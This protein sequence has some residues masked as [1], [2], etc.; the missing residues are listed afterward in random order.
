M[1]PT[2][3]GFMRK[4]L[5]QALRD[6]RM[7][8]LILVMPVI[9]LTL[10]GLALNA[11]TRNIR[12]AVLAAPDD[13]IAARLADRA[14]TS[15]WFVRVDADPANPVSALKAGTADAILI[16]PP[17]GATK[18]F[19]HGQA[20]F[21]L[22]TDASNAVRARSVEN[23]VN[24]ILGQVLE[25]LL[26]GGTPR[27]PIHLDVRVLY[28]PAMRSAVFMIPAVLAMILLLVSQQLTGL[29]LAREKELGTMEMLLAAPV[30]RWE[31]LIG[32]TLP[33]IL[34]ALLDVP[35]ALAVAVGG[36]GVP[37]RG[38]LWELVGVAILFVCSTAAFGTLI[39]TFARNQQQAM[40]GGFLFTF[41]ANLL[42]GLMF[43]LDTLPWPVRFVS[44]L[45]P[46]RYFISV[47]RNIMLKGGHFDA[48]W[49]S[50]LALA[51]LAVV[52]VTISA[53]RFHATL[54]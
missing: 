18:A 29:S 54:D 22:L 52:A 8:M 36:F 24:A 13:R 45:N 17:G 41:P 46:L 27:P 35:I 20:T 21:Q 28:N 2:I 31:I 40:M 33:Y 47:M 34:L 9:Q 50:A 15:G 10:F 38:P 26:P 44:Y 25:D 6:P 53:R 42:S 49:P 30:S 4:E 37:M 19:G 14:F 43:P 11:E 12:L 23:Y 32:K 51:A 39:S 48:V 7:L 3:L 16:A 1:N 5:A